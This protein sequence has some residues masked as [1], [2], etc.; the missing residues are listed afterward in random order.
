MTSDEG[1]GSRTSGGTEVD[2]TGKVDPQVGRRRRATLSDDLT[3]EILELIKAE[4][5]R[6]GDRLPPVQALSDRFGVATSTL[7]EA[8]RRLQA[9]NAVSIRHGSGIYVSHDRHRRI[10]ANPHRDIADARTVR[11]LLETRRLIEPAAARA[12]AVKANPS[13]LV[14]AHDLLKEAR[15]HLRDENALTTTNMAFHVCVARLSGNLILAETIE[16]LLTNHTE[17]QHDILVL[18]EDRAKDYHEHCA[19][20]NALASNDGER[21]S[22][23]MY[24]HLTGVIEGVARRAK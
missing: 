13:A 16:A 2:E 15:E 10:L 23:Q 8:L 21:A 7:R 17:E 20:L 18:Y 22:R 24:E 11:E 3:R 1:G 9:T 4:R 14:P 5:L 19:I 12:A 6:P